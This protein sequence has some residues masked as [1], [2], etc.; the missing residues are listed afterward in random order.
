MKLCSDGVMERKLTFRKVV[1]SML[2]D[3]YSFLP[4]DVL[5]TMV[6][7]PP[8]TGVDPIIPIEFR[9][10][11]SQ[12]LAPAGEFKNSTYDLL[13]GLDGR[14]KIFSGKELML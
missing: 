13:S 14:V 8:V 10:V 6:P 1:L 12:T 9:S 2:L 7:M 5:G 11:I 3:T 4:V